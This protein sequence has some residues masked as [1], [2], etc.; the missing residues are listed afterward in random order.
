[1]HQNLKAGGYSQN[2]FIPGYSGIPFCD[3][4]YPGGPQQIPGR[5]KCAYYDVGGE[6]VAYH[7][8]ESKNKGSGCLNPNNGSY[9]NTFR[10]NEAVG[11]SYTKFVD[12][13]DNNPYNF[14]QISP[15]QLYVGWTAE[16][17]WINY[18]IHVVEP[19]LY[20]VALLY[21]S[22]GPNQLSLTIDNVNTTGALKLISTY[23]AEDPIAWRQWHHWNKM[24]IARLDLESGLHLLTV[25]IE[26]GG[27][28]NLDCLEFTRI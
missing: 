21:T 7:K 9:L 1:M 10:M 3:S 24:E 16:G 25:K 13:I 5:I 27:N 20:S 26:Y 11:I 4:V 18:T 23:V 19:G 22:N 8:L 12:E 15:E 14:I 28:I 6:G 2:T 17:E